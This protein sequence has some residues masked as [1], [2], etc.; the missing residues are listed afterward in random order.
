MTSEL[1][2]KLSKGLLLASL[3]ML[4]TLAFAADKSAE[5]RGRL[6]AAA[7][8]TA[9]DSAG[10]APW[11]WKL[12]VSLSDSNG[13]K[14]SVGSLEMWSSG[15]NMLMRYSLRGEQMTVLRTGDKLYRTPGDV[16]QLPVAAFLEMQLVHPIPDQV[17]A[18]GVTE[19]MTTQRSGALEVEA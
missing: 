3:S 17:F 6:K 14:P 12:D 19:K 15:G 18:A 11:H 9:M 7:Q 2:S 8:L 10:L 4:T 1:C 5:L 16:K 13:A